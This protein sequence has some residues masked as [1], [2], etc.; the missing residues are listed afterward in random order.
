MLRPAGLW[1]I[2]ALTALL[3]VWASAVSAYIAFH[4]DLLSAVVTRQAAMESAYESRLAEARARLD[5]VAGERALDLKSFARKLS[6]L[7]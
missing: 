5:E 1:A 7:A 2:A 4:D 3:I 6:E